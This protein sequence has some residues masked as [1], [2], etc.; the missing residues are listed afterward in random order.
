[1]DLKIVIFGGNVLRCDLVLTI[2]FNL[3]LPN[4]LEIFSQQEMSKIIAVFVC[5]CLVAQ[6]LFRL[7]VQMLV[8]S[9]FGHV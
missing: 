7:S 2:F 3:K 4:N 5:M 8:C 6:L 1:M 9:R